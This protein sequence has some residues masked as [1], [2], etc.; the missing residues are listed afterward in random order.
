MDKD[1]I[2][3]A[4]A[5]EPPS[6]RAANQRELDRIRAAYA[7]R[8]LA[9]PADRYARIRPGN[10][11]SLHEREQAMAA[12][13]RAAGL[14]SLRGLRILD[15][16]CGLGGTLRQ[17]LEYGAE[18]TRLFGVDLLEGRLQQAQRLG[19][20]LQWACGSAARLP[21]SDASFDVI[22]QFTL[23][24]SVLSDAIKRAIAEEILRVLA[25]DGRFLWYDF[26]YNNPKNPDVRGIGRS[27]IRRLFPGCAIRLRPITLAPP[28]GRLVARLSPALYHALT[29]VR[30][31]CTHYLGLLE[32]P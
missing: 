17:L 23:F 12:F 9:V 15:L 27:E 7:R 22:L 20:H 5:L 14:E 18:P 28:L 21:F 1:L 13:L 11:C 24:T 6:R 3:T 29:L 26:A 25:P 2:A 4:A 32:K 30:P 10:L 8:S 19:P 31:L 16:G